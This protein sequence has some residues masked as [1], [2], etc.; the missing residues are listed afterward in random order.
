MN[1]MALLTFSVLLLFSI[2]MTGCQ[3]AGQQLPVCYGATGSA[4]LAEQ[5]MDESFCLWPGDRISIKFFYE[6]RLDDEVL[7]G[8]DGKVSLHLIGQVKAAGLTP[9]QLQALLMDEYS[10]VMYPGCEISATEKMSPYALAVGSVVSV[11]FFRNSELNDDLIIRPDGKISIALIGEVKAAGL[12]PTELEALLSKRYSKAFLSED[13]QSA[14]VSDTAV[15]NLGQSEVTVVVREFKIPELK[16]SVSS[17]SARMVYVTGEITSPRPISMEHGVIRV[18][19]AVLQAGGTL[20][21]AELNKILL[22]RCNENQQPDV[23]AVNLKNILNGVE[24]NFT[25]RPYDIVYV[26]KTFIANVATFVQQY[27]HSII[28]VQFNLI[29]DLNDSVK[30]TN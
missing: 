22:I 6:S 1:K 27:I 24:P 19:D 9:N 7:I 12:T 20:D 29:Y 25:L 17:S 8:P 10:R 13:Q 23:Y 14:N 11:R 15:G 16:V 30:I 3:Q 2:M 5:G 18:L 28:P 21:T 26:P 4:L